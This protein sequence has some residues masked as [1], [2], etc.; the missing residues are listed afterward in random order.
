MQGN[1]VLRTMLNSRA[2]NQIELSAQLGKSANYVSRML[3]G[4]FNPN[5]KTL[6][7]FCEVL[8]YQIVIRDT[9]DGTELLIDP[10]EK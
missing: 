5:L 9:S 1:Q 6:A 2:I 7:E 3:A 8:G 10:P 4:G